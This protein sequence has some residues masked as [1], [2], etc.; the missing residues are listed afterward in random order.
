MQRLMSEVADRLGRET[1][2]IQRERQLSGGQFAQ[3]VVFGWMGNPTASLKE[4][5][6]LAAC[7]QVVISRQGLDQRFTE[8]AA[9]FMQ[10]LLAATMEEVGQGPRV[11]SKLF[12]EFSGV[13]LLD[14]TCISLP[15]ELHDCWP[16]CGG[17]A[18]ESACLKVSVLWE[19][20]HGGLEAIELLPGK[21]HDQRAQAAQCPLPRRSVRLADLGYFKLKGLARMAQEGEDWVSKYKNGT[22]VW[23]EGQRIDVL[24]YLEAASQPVV[25]GPVQIGLRLRLP[26]RLVAR[27]VSPATLER[28]QTD[29]AEWER[30]KQG[31]ASTQTWALLAWDICLTTLPATILSTEAVLAF[32]H[33]RW[34]IELLFKL[35]KSEGRV[36][37][38]RTQNPWRVLCEIYAKLIALIFQHWFMVLG[39]WHRLDRSLT[40]A[41]HTSRHFAW[42]FVRTLSS[43]RRLCATLTD[44]I[45]CLHHCHMDKHQVSPR[46]FQRLEALT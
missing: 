10:A 5:S 46:T 4:M 35:W 9:H 34:Q 23:V 25:D 42:Q 28:R 7:N 43:R 3:T 12:N 29:L 22:V 18:G 39:T 17:S 2:F 31:R 13:Y 11:M 27:R 1:G 33:Y 21:T 36:D 20:L 44:L 40:Q 14:S 8:R 30:K 45:R 26:V 24:S 6:Q 41:L 19:M 32:A 37:E 38:W 15:V 16:G